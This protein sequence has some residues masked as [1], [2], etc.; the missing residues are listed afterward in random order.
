MRVEHP[1]RAALI[2]AACLLFPR[3]A[4]AQQNLACDVEEM[5]SRRAAKCLET[6]CAT[7]GVGSIG[8]IDCIT[9]EL[10]D[11]PCD[12]STANG[13]ADCISDI[14]SQ[15]EDLQLDPQGRPFSLMEKC[16]RRMTRSAF[17]RALTAAAK[18][19]IRGRR[20]LNLA[21]RFEK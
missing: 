10:D 12:N 6:E 15:V 5:S 19:E 8:R 1:A 2:I 3:T 4:R 16:F 20:A 18:G 9:S 13:L 17:I 7:T 11:D 21:H 14:V